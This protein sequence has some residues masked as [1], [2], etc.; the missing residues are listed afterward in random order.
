MRIRIRK[1]VTRSNPSPVEGVY[2]ESSR[3]IPYLLCN[4]PLLLDRLDYAESCRA[5]SH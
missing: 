4:Q 2:E 3:T 5:A 1:L